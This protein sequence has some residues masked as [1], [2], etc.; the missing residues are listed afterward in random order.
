MS[1][2]L[3]TG[4]SGFVGSH[5][6]ITLLEN[7]YKLVV[8][9]NEANSTSKCLLRIKNFFEDKI[10][11]IEKKLI[12]INSD[13]RNF[14]ELI[15]IFETLERKNIRIDFVIHLAGLKDMN[16]SILRSIEYW[17]NNVLG[18]INLFK[19]MEKFNCRNIVFSSS[20]AIYDARN[21]QKFNEDSKKYPLNPYGLTKFTIEKILHNLYEGSSY[22][23]NII[24]LRYFNPAGAHYSGNFGE[25]PLDKSS[26]LFP[27]ITKVAVGK[28][29]FIKIFGRD[30]GTKDGTAERDFV[31]V[32]DLAEAHLLAMEYLK[33]KKK[34]FIS[35]NIGSGQRTSILNLIRTFEKVNKCQIPIKYCDRRK[36]DVAVLS[37]DIELAKD[38]L[39]WEPK[40]TIIDICKDGWNWQSKNP[41]G[42]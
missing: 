6:C 36:G 40:K 1:H 26:N 24:N 21:T 8:I 12:F 7:N 5:I 41:N 34:L 25:S 23:W 28:L 35:I 15:E 38:I 32:T 9:D 33:N 10:S 29:D 30:W 22:P 13:L 27:L 11:Q 4:G 37:A 14:Y 42:Y 2:I 20:A 39:K 19:V 16:K 3:I 31:H 17:D 18:S